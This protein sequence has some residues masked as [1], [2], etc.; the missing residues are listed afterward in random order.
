MITEKDLVALFEE[1]RPY[2]RSLARRRSVDN[3]WRLNAEDLEAE[4]W[5]VM[6][7][8][9]RLGKYN[10]DHDTFVKV[11]RTS[12]N[13]ALGT[14]RYHETLTFR[15]DTMYADSTEVGMDDE[16]SE[17]V[18]IPCQEPLPEECIEAKEQ[19][20]ALSLRMSELQ[21]RMLDIVSG[22]DEKA[23]RYLRLLIKRRSY[24]FGQ[25]TITIDTFLLSR[26]LDV[27]KLVISSEI[28]S[29]RKLMGV[30]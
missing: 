18:E 9:F 2:I 21:K 26:V 7:K 12:A 16:E 22:N 28:C 29:L 1:Q 3:H 20:A 5:M 14:L 15:R 8:L 30:G 19:L 11:F 27:S 23:D 25:P 4:C 17:L 24:V 13:H 6:V 10:S